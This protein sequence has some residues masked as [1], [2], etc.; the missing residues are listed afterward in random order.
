MSNEPTTEAPERLWINHPR[1][2]VTRTLYAPEDRNGDPLLGD[3]EYIRA[4][5]TRASAAPAGQWDAAIDLVKGLLPELERVNK[6]EVANGFIGTSYE[7]GQTKDII[8]LLEAARAAQI[9]AQ[10]QLPTLL[11]DRVDLIEGE[12]ISSEVISN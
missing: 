5:L 11:Q 9:L 10:T 3:V 7:L 2:M 6:I 1:P 12:R 8:E 4:D